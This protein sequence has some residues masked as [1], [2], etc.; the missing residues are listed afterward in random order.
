MYYVV[1]VNLDGDYSISG[2]GLQGSYLT[3]Q[4]HFHWGSTLKQGSEHLVDSTAYPAEIHVVHYSDRFTSVP[5]AANDPTGLAVLGVF[6]Q[7]SNE[8]NSNFNTIISAIQDVQQAGNQSEIQ[9]FDLNSILPDDLTRFYRYPG[10]LTT[11]ECNEAIVWTVFKK[12]I[13]LSSSQ[14]ARFRTLQNEAGEPIKDNFRPPQQLN[15]RKVVFSDPDYDP[16]HGSV[17]VP[18]LLVSIFSFVMFTFLK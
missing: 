7:E 17:L 2:G 14:I 16:S 15:G 3:A 13:S 10:S 18:S 11:P 5:A 1:Q 8:D 6:I 12:P 4:F 9:V